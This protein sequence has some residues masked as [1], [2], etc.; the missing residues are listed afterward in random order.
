MKVVFLGET[1]KGVGE[2]GQGRGGSQVQ[3]RGAAA[4]AC[5]GTPVHASPFF[6]IQEGSCQPVV[7]AG[8]GREDWKVNL[9]DF[10][11][12]AQAGKWLRGIEI[13]RRGQRSGERMVIVTTCGKHP[14]L[15]DSL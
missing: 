2:A 9:R 7:G 5:R 10:W 6:Q 4:W 13:V 8:T 12:S 11:L 14:H 1:E 3:K 15:T